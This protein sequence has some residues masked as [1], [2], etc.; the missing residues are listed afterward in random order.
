MNTAKKTALGGL[1]TALS[2]VLMIISNIIPFGLYTFPTLAGILTYILSTACGKSYG[3]YSFVAVSIISFILCTDK[4]TALCYILFLGYYPLVKEALEKIHFKLLSYFL[5]LSVF[6]ASAVSVYF[7]MLYV[8]SLSEEQFKIF[9]INLPVVFLVM[10]NII[11]L[12]YDYVLTV[13]NKK[14]CFYIIQIITK[15]FK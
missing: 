7:I 9:G 2:S 12:L 3:W 15:M 8:F 1:V 13:F 10:L 6:N 4:E 14:Y 5:K 11:F